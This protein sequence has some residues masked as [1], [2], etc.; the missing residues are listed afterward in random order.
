MCDLGVSLAF[1]VLARATSEGPVP[2]PLP[3]PIYIIIFSSPSCLTSLTSSSLSSWWSLI[4]KTV[5]FFYS[6]LSPC[7]TLLP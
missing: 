2:N 5:R 4:K 7:P 6:S 3:A 1:R